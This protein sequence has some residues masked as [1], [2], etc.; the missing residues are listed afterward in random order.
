M[1]QIFFVLTKFFHNYYNDIKI[2]QFRKK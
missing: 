2:I 1:R